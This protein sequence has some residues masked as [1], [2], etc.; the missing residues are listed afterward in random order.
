MEEKIR[1]ELYDKLENE[2]DSYKKS[3]L[4]LSNKE[5]IDKS[6]ETAIKEIRALK[7]EENSLD[8]LYR[9][10]MDCDL[11]ICQLLEDSV[12]D[13]LEDIVEEQKEKIKEAKKKDRER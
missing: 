2:L 12:R 1:Q 8:S 11:N 3:L 7:Q 6:Y 9:G 5:V 4:E 10:W 13:T